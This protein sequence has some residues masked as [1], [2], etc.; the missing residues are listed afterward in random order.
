MQLVI[1]MHDALRMFR[2]AASNNLCLICVAPENVFNCKLNSHLTS[3]T[4]KWS[5]RGVKSD[6]KKCADKIFEQHSFLQLTHF[7]R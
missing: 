6:G 2:T 1:Q 7:N 5:L 3:Q 4:W